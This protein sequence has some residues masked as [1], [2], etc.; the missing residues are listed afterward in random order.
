MVEI[1][2]VNPDQTKVGQR[3]S[4]FSWI[5]LQAVNQIAK[6]GIGGRTSLRLSDQL[7][8]CA[9]MYE[10]GSILGQA[11]NKKTILLVSKSL[12]ESQQKRDASSSLFRRLE[13]SKNANSLYTFYLFYS[14]RNMIMDFSIQSMKEAHKIVRSINEVINYAEGAG[15]EGFILGSTFPYLVKELYRKG[16]DRRDKVIL[17]MT[18]YG[19][20]FPEETSLTSIEEREK[21]IMEKVKLYFSKDK[22][23]QATQ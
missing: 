4:L 6:P 8:L 18:R 15:I 13:T 3:V 10:T 19:I 22:L 16:D 9:F 11:N 21:I 23:V 1:I 2:P 12:E 7:Q 14:L 20:I 5:G 17:E